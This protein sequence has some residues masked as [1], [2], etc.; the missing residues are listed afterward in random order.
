MHCAPCGFNALKT[1][2]IEGLASLFRLWYYVIVVRQDSSTLM[3]E[4]EFRSI[5][6]TVTEGS[7]DSPHCAPPPPRQ[8]PWKTGLA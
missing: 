4:A 1:V 3:G 2:M 8:V 6:V 7:V 5:E